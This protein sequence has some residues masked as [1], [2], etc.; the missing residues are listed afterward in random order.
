MEAG[1][2]VLVGSSIRYGVARGVFSN[3]AGLGRGP[4]RRRG[5]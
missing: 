3:E 1:F 2:G 5:R 4:Y